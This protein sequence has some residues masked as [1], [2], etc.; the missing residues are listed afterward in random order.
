MYQNY[1]LVCI[2]GRLFSVPPVEP[3]MSDFVALVLFVAPDLSPM[4]SF[5][6]S[7]SSVPLYYYSQKSSQEGKILRRN[8]G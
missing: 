6:S 3:L 2:Q 5:I 8:C 4:T 7:A 1:R